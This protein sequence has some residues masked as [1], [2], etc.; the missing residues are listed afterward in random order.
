M[1]RGP[2]GDAPTDV[3]GA[4]IM[5]G[6]IATGEIGEAPRRMTGWT[7]QRLPLGVRGKGANC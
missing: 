4:A 1:P 7:R 2:R 3:I 6:N 5:V